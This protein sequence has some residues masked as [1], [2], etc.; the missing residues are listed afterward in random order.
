MNRGR[1]RPSETV[2]N[3]RRRLFNPNPSS[4]IFFPS[5]PKKTYPEM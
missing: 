5:K 3:A 4:Y 1:E 2:F